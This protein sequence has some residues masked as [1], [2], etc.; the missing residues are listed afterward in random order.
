M[1]KFETFGSSL[2]ALAVIA[3]GDSF[4]DITRDLI[5]TPPACDA[6]NTCTYNCCANTVL[7]HLYFDTFVLVMQFILLNTVV[8]CC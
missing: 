1:I 8:V 4:H 7:V 6:S 2:L 3:G 5:R